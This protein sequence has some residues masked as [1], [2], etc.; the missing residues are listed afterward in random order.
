MVLTVIGW[1]LFGAL[2][3]W[4][5]SIIMKTN[6][7]MGPAANILTGILGALL[8]GALFKILPF[9]HQDAN[10]FDIGSLI[11]S[12]IGACILIAVLRK[13]TDR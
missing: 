7:D 9:A 3:G 10:Q 12:I 5:A 8:G 2:A 4:I 13:V 6:E 11:V 1:I